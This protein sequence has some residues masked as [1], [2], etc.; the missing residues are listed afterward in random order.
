M[1]LFCIIRYYM[2]SII[3]QEQLIS[4]IEG[5]G[6]TALKTIEHAC[7]PLPRIAGELMECIKRKKL[8]ERRL[9]GAL[10]VGTENNRGLR[11]HKL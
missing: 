1:T 6:N 3:K 9:H 10:K 8:P 7:G 5:S 11:G 2:S 4:R